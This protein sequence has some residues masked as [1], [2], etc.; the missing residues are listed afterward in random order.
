MAKLYEKNN[1][2]EKAILSLEELL[3][4]KS[5]S[6]SKNKIY[7]LLLKN[8]FRIANFSQA[9]VVK[10]RLDEAYKNQQLQLNEI[11][12]YLIDVTNLVHDDH[13]LDLGAHRRAERDDLEIAAGGDGL[14]VA[15]DRLDAELVGAEAAAPEFAAPAAPPESPV[16]VP[17]P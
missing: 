15:L 7:F 6:I 8:H 1:E 2:S 17:A 5:S 9:E 12:E 10:K 11:Y 3:T 14:T 4:R 16:A 13:V